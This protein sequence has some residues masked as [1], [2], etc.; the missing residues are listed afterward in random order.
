MKL[1]NWGNFIL[2]FIPAG[3]KDYTM[4]LVPFVTER[5]PLP[6]MLRTPEVS[7]TEASLLATHATVPPLIPSSKLPPADTSFTIS[8]GLPS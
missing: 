2:I 4:P 1:P 8:Y 6:L 7:E 3:R 5:I